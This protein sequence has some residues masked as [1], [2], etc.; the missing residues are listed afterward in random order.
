MFLS[1]DDTLMIEHH[2]I[3]CSDPLLIIMMS[4]EYTK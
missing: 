2:C 3:A 4:M 1:N